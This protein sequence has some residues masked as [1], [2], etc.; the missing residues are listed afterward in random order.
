MNINRTDYLTVKLPEDTANNT[1]ELRAYLVNA[2]GIIVET[3][4]FEGTE[5]RIK[6]T[7]KGDKVYVGAALPEVLP[8]SK[9]NER[10]L[11]DMSAYQAV[12]NFAGSNTI[13]IQR[14]PDTIYQFPPFRFCNVTG[15]VN[16]NFIINGQTTNLPICNARVHICNVERI[17]YWP[18]YL[19]PK[20]RIPD[21]VLEELKYKLA[22]VN[23]PVIKVPPRPDPGPL[24]EATFTKQNL[25]LRS[26]TTKAKTTVE[27]SANK[28][29]RIPEYVISD[30][31]SA[32]TE[33]IQQ[34]LIQ[35][36]DI[37]YP[38]LCIWPIFWPWFYS[39]QE[40]AVVYTDCNGHFDAWL[41]FIGNN[42]QENIYTWVEV[43]INGQW[44]TVYR[45][46]FPCFTKWNYTC[47][48]NIN[49][50]L[51]DTRVLPCA[52]GAEGP[53]DA[54]WFRSIGSAAGALHIEQSPSNTRTIQG[55]SF[56][57]VG[58]TDIL[59]YDYISPFGS[60]L[61][62]SVFAGENVYSSGTGVTHFRWRATRVKDESLT[63]IPPALQSSIILNAA[64]K[65]SREYMVHLDTF[66]YH[67]FNLDIA[68]SGAG[69]NIA[70]RIP[71]Q[72]IA[73]ESSITAAF[74]GKTPGVDIFWRDIFWTGGSIDSRSLSDG[75]Y[76]FD[77]ELGTYNGAGTFVIT[78]VDPRTFQISQ[79]ADLDNSQ[80]ATSR[81]VNMNGA[82]ARNFTM[83]VR[84]DNA[85]CT[86]DIHDAQLN[87]TGALSGPCGF[88]IYSDKNAQHIHL[89]FEA[90]HP[91]NFAR[92]GFNVIKGN[93][94]ENTGIHPGGYV[95]T[96]IGDFSLAAG[97]YSDDVTVASLL[98]TCPGQAAF[99]ENLSV[100]SIA[101]DGSNRLDSY[102]ASDVNAFALSNT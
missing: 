3:A 101:T 19:Q 50:T 60:T 41:F 21:W 17:F 92:F 58:C 74:P 43:N 9:A 73:L 34:S 31:Q 8:S 42:T 94:T 75:L 15:H 98:G 69:N 66:H 89:S 5:A 22:T 76:R 95:N 40:E 4:R 32:T 33:T 63:D 68:P 83:L 48:T 35:Y 38:Y 23:Q 27:P 39:V 62:L 30:I 25:S 79:L 46:P 90:S 80:D 85:H 81:Y 53:G 29:Q 65:I 99:S 7:G 54:F 24:R 49:I 82:A 72:N 2:A 28:L 37:L 36:H 64:D 18:I 14:L 51:T 57:N 84:I 11:A 96:S 88:I 71:N 26:L 1:R 16:K 47:N 12:M 55:A 59:G 70:F 102:D 91:R 61:N 6:S 97:I 20:F 77:L 13:H 93:N 67:S 10:T 87:E 44:V 100:L 52:C 56:A 45:P 78:E 86:A